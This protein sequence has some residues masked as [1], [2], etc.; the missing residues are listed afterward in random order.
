MIVGQEVRKRPMWANGGLSGSHKQIRYSEAVKLCHHLRKVPNKGGHVWGKAFFDEDKK[1][2]AEQENLKIQ[3]S[4]G[5]LE[6]G[7]GVWE[8]VYK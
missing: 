8:R 1:K 2:Q 6:A 7:Q 4:V 3:A 5:H